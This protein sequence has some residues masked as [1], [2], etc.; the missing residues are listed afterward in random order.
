MKLSK[1]QSLVSL[2]LVSAGICHTQSAL[3]QPTSRIQQLDNTAIRS[4]AQRV[5]ERGTLHFRSGIEAEPAEFLATHKLDLGLTEVDTFEEVRRQSREVRGPAGAMAEEVVRFRQVHRGIPVEG[6]EYVVRREGGALKV[7]KGRVAEGLSID[8]ARRMEETEALALALEHVEAKV[9]AWQG[10]TQEA[11]KAGDE[12]TLAELLTKYPKGE[13]VIVLDPSSDRDAPR[14]LLT[15]KF[16]IETLEPFGSKTVY[17][18]AETGSMVQKLTDFHS[19]KN[20]VGTVHTVYNGTHTFSTRRR[21]FPIWDYILKD[22]TRG[23]IHVKHYSNVDGWG[24]NLAGHIDQNSNTWSRREASIH[25]AAQEAHDY[26]RSS[27]NRHGVNGS[28]EELRIHANAPGSA[29]ADSGGHSRLFFLSGHETLDVVGHEFTHG[30]IRHTSNLTYANESGALNESFADIFG[31]MVERRVVGDANYD[32]LMGSDFGT[33]RNMEDPQTVP[34]PARPQPDTRGGLFWRNQAGCVPTDTNDWCW[35]HTNSGVQNRWYSL[36]VDGGTHNGVAVAG[37]GET[38]AQRVAY[39]NMTVELFPAADHDDAREGAIDAATV[40]Y[41]A[42]SNVVAQ[43][44]NAWAAVGVGP[45]FG[46]CIPPLTGRI[47]GPFSGEIGTR[48]TWNAVASGGVP[49]YS[50]RWVVGNTIPVTGTSVS[51]TFF[52]S[53]VQ[54]IQL[55]VTDSSGRQATDFLDFLVVGDCGGRACIE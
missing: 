8:P 34:W 33:I 18:D 26:F 29:Y 35:V 11:R 1:I 39:R 6:A 50:Y 49:P 41:G 40:L 52:S 20:A 13:L 51:R 42:C 23:E 17:L 21:Q 10:L 36:L 28:N 37:V 46:I 54:P 45:T 19:A 14:F 48:Y 32:W 22:K 4:V 53:G 2:V 9:Y 30:V 43:V 27:F 16:T 25:W 24:W 3:A 55:T 5:T 31:T 7:L 12:Q 38:V 44:T 47:S 15:W